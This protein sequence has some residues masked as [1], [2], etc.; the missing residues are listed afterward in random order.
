M[1][2]KRIHTMPLAPDDVFDALLHVRSVFPDVVMVIFAMDGRWQYLT[3]DFRAPRFN[4]KIDTSILE[5][6]ANAAEEEGLPVIYQIY[7]Y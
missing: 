2:T 4:S 6:A 5:R 3:E 1:K 7:E